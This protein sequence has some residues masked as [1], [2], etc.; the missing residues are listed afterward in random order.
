ML[1]LMNN[2]AHNRLYKYER[3]ISHQKSRY[4][5]TTD[6][7]WTTT[8]EQ[9]ITI[10]QHKTKTK[11]RHKLQEKLRK[12]IHHKDK[13]NNKPDTWIRNLSS[14]R[15]S[16]TEKA[17]LFCGLNYNHKDAN[18]ET[19]FMAALE[20]TLKDTKLTD[21]TQQAIRQTIILTLS[22]R[23]E[24]DTLNASERKALE[25]LK[26]DKDIVIPPTDKGRMTVIMNKPD[27]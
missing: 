24:W 22:K 3:E 12:L 2:D 6:Q 8:L 20:T 10:K 23:N 17:V 4:L 16:E 27:Y 13:D 5:N 19:D 14:R 15:L 1:Q 25:K 18:K 7:Q 11:K 9:T 26:K 21:E